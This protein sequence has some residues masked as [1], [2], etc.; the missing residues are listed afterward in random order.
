MS[1]ATPNPLYI[2]GML[3][4]V[5][6]WVRDEISAG[7]LAAGYD[8]LTSAHV[9]LFRHPT[10]D[11]QRPSHLAEQ[12]QITKQSVNDLLGHLQARGYITRQADPTDRRARVVRLTSKGKRLERVVND[13]ARAA[14]LAI[15]DMLGPRRFEQLRSAIAD[16]ASEVSGRAEPRRS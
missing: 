3:R 13:Q 6:Q 1:S 16:V 4:Q 10:L 7:V 5:W 9:A 12:M 2:G 15:A 11:R 14:E 8:D